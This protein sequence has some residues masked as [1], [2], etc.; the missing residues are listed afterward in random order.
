MLDLISQA[1]ASVWSISDSVAIGLIQALTLFALAVLYY[2]PLAGLI[3]RSDGLEFSFAGTKVRSFKSFDAIRSA[4]EKKK[5]EGLQPAIP[6]ADLRRR[7][8]N[9]SKDRGLMRRLVLWVDDNPD[10]NLLER[11]ALEA[12]GIR[13]AIGLDTNT[14]LQTFRSTPFDL[15]ISDMG[16][17][18]GRTA[19]LDLLRQLKQIQPAV[20]VLFYTSSAG[21]ALAKEFGITGATQHPDELYALVLGELVKR[22]S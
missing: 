13:I 19:G 6:D 12:L 14:A 7:A 20:P 9:A 21:V 18:E 16:R 11:N 5:A 17:P 22:H 15:V 10:N 8:R 1:C 4:T 2:R 3:D